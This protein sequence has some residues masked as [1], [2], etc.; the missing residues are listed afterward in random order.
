V[1]KSTRINDASRLQ[2]QKGKGGAYS[3]LPDR[4]HS[5]LSK[6]QSF[7]YRSHSLAL[8]KSCMRMV[9]TGLCHEAPKEAKGQWC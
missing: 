4:L 3:P 8:R 5:N 1:S 9:F 6:M 7:S 2:L